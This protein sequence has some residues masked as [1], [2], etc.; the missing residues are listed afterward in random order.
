MHKDH[1]LRLGVPEIVRL[2]FTPEDMPQLAD[3]IARALAGDAMSVAAEVRER[4]T[5]LNG[6][7]YIVR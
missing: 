6:L 3:W 5:R 7:R 4:R 2:G 1:G